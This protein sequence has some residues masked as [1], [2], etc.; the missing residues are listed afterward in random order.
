M[1]TQKWFT[2]G[3]NVYI[4]SKKDRHEVKTLSKILGWSPPH[5][6]MLQMPYLN[7]A[8]LDISKGVQCVVRYLFDGNLYGFETVVIKLQFDPIPLLFLKYPQ[9]IENVSLRKNK[10]VPSFIP[11][12]VA[13]T[14]SPDGEQNGDQQEEDSQ[15][16][17][18]SEVYDG[19][20]LDISKSGCQLSMKNDLKL[21]S[22]I[23]LTFT[24]PPQQTI[25]KLKC[26]VRNSRKSKDS[27]MIG[28]EF[29]FSESKDIKNI[30]DEFFDLSKKFRI[31][32]Q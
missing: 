7:G 20:I 4:Y 16:P 19:T 10:R 9:N 30:F 23:S 29:D 11:V 2:V 25:E 15:S 14:A 26:Y 31:K 1:S 24:L 32:D 22:E 18:T 13:V 17:D 12:K 5:F 8:P 21:N 6:V 27:C 3:V 28:I